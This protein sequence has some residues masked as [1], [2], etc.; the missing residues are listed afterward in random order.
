MEKK[1]LNVTMMREHRSR[2]E[3]ARKRKWEDKTGGAVD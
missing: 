3:D 1:R 2:D